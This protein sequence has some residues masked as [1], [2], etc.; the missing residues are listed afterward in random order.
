MKGVQAWNISF[1]PISIY[2]LYD[3]RPLPDGYSGDGI[4]WVLAESDLE[5]EYTKVTGS[6]C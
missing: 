5:G 1:A 6:L 2:K 4:G 3:P